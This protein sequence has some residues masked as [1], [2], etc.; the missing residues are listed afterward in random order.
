MR[1]QHLK[2]IL[3]TRKITNMNVI[4]IKTTKILPKNENYRKLSL[5]AIEYNP[6]TRLNIFQCYKT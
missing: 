5:K 2:N 6:Q 3:N 4:L 1:G